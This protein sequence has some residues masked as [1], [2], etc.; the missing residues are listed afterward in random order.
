MPNA[1]PGTAQARMGTDLAGHG[2][3]RT[4][5]APSGSRSR[6]DARKADP[7][8]GRGMALSGGGAGQPS[9]SHAIIHMACD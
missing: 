3:A 4:A 8:A 6:G 9:A 7:R 2:W 1:L 5:R